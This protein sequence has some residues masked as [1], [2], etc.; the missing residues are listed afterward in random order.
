MLE[1]ETPNTPTAA[2]TQFETR[3]FVETDVAKLKQSLGQLPEPI[4][5]P[6]LVI[7][8]GLPGTGKSFFCRKLATR[9]PAC[10][11]ESDAMRKILFPTPQYTATEN[12]RL[13]AA[14][15]VVIESLLKQ[16]IPVIFDATNLLER[17][18]ERLYNIAEKTGARLVL[19]QV[20]APPSVTYQRLRA[21]KEQ[22]NPEDNSDAD[23]EVYKRMRQKVDKIW[24]NHFVVDTSRDLTPIL[25]KIVRFLTR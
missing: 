22:R 13:F 7:V 3:A 15:H 4:V 18:R 20:T 10:V 17:H 9:F 8:S 16:G 6:P 2:S 14:C 23:W 11:V 21:R 1:H 19:V 24:R 25:D 12:A 5:N